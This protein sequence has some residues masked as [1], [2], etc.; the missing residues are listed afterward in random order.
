[1]R[2]P[3]RPLFFVLSCGFACCFPLSGCKRAPG[4]AEEETQI[5]PVKAEH[6]EAAVFGEW[7]E[8]IGA[9]QPVPGRI[10]R[11]TAPLEGHVLSVL[12]GDNGKPIA[13]GQTVEKEQV[14]AR[15]DDRVARAQR[16]KVVAS[17]SELTEAHTQADLAH[18]LAT[19]DLERLTKLNPSGASDL[20]SKIEVEK[21]RLA[22][23]DAKSK[24]R[25]VTAKE[26]TLQAELRGLDLHLAYHELRAPIRGVLGPLQVVPGQTLAVGAVVADVIDLGEIDVVAFAP[27]RIAVK[28]R[29]NEAAAYADKG[30][31]TNSTTTSAT[32]RLND[33]A[34]YADKGQGPSDHAS[35]EGRVVFIADQAQPDTG[36]VLVKV[37]FPNSQMRLRANQVAR[38]LVLTQEPKKRLTI[39]ATCLM[40]DQDPPLVVVADKVTVKKHPEHGDEEIGEARK[41]RAYLGIRDR[42]EQRVEILR[43][44]DAAAKKDVSVEDA[45]FIVEGGH[46]LHDG[47]AVKITGK[48]EH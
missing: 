14:I 22:Q 45:L 7:T 21:A 26:K 11:I 48:K 43:L 5:A 8:L 42:A 39:P 24:Q 2:R 40:E 10:A 12:Q 37:R 31:S 41:L 44:E 33:A 3:L 4:P 6:A 17:L 47:D 20:V 46:G 15:L 29:L 1:M 28:L 19:L 38:V 25:A 30:Q 36:S 9:T 16:D 18:Q 27:P 13:E 35:P 23:Q 32:S 34:A